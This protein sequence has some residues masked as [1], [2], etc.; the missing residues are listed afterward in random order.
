LKSTKK[1]KIL[2]IIGQL[3]I[4]GTEIHI[5]N[6]AKNIDRDKYDLSVF[7][8]KKGGTLHKDFIDNHIPI[9]GNNYNK[10]GK[11]ALLI[12][13]IE[14]IFISFRHKP[15][16]FHFFLPE[17][18]ILGFISTSLFRKTER[19]MSRRSLNDYQRKKMYK[20]FRLKYLEK[21]F[22]KRMKYITGNSLAVCKQLTEEG[23]EKNKIKLIY[24]GVDAK[25]FENRKKTGKKNLENSELVIICVANLIPYKGHSD[26][27]KGIEYIADTLHRLDI[28]GWRLLFVGRDDG[29]GQDFQWEI[30]Q[31]HR[32]IMSNI[33]F[34]GEV[35]D[36]APLIKKSDIGV[37]CSHQEGFSN[38][39]LECM[40]AGLPMVVT[41]VGGNS[42]VIS[43]GINGLIVESHSPK[44]IGEA[45][46]KLA[47]SDSLRKKLGNAA[48]KEIIE[49]YN[50][51]TCIKMYEDLYSEVISDN[52]S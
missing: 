23:V 48:Y 41:N 11:I 49:K 9:L 19:I 14:L 36:V 43:D 8:L 51:S 3:D 35:G 52:Q 37:L 32:A 4:G 42:E 18:Y 7:P 13:L 31:N 27:V 25:R 1:I 28:I 22:H 39:I 33:E 24:N 30:W 38:S 12:S 45:I 2:V 17:A 5:L 46:L 26:L 10:L 15:D 29:Y 34:L 21:A 47:K 40:A 50:L 44:Q 20:F 16:I 6:L